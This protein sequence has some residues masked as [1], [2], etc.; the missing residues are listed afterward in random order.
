MAM[1]TG[2]T[3]D[4]VKVKTG[5]SFD[6]GATHYAADEYLTIHGFATG[7]LWRYDQLSGQSKAGEWIHEKR[8]IWPVAPFA[9]VH[10]C[11]VH[12]PAHWVVM[13]S[14][15]SVLDPLTPEYKRLCDYS[16]VM[17]IT[18]VWRVVNK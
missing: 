2:E 14:D 13:R 9:P 3:Y 6:Y 1:I 4:E 11:Q 17:Q 8:C 10:L 5:Q 7:R 16:E 12:S 18:G 15:G